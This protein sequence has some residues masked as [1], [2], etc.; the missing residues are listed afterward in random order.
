A[1]GDVIGYITT[2][3][4]K[5]TPAGGLSRRSWLVGEIRSQFPKVPVLLLDTG[6]FSDNPT[7]GG[8]RRTRMLLETMARL[9]TKVA[10][11]GER[12][13]ALGY[14]ELE[15]RLSGIDMTFVSTNVVEEGTTKPV[16]PPYAVVEV[17]GRD[18]AA[19]R[20]GVLDVLRFNP[21][22]QKAGPK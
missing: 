11:I 17:Q 19:I 1:T 16:F 5:L 10:G 20:V 18:G 15:K 14:D 21:T 8:E 9:G 22:W 7:P 3:G 6:N 4:C 13:L 12:E 2:C